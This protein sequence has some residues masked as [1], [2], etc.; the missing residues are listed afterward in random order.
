M[1]D[2]ILYLQSCYYFVKK[3]GKY[4]KYIVL[5]MVA[6]RKWT[7]LEFHYPIC[8]LHEFQICV[9]FDILYLASLIWFL[10]R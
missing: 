8:F 6:Y 7:I 3:K 10:F 2:A 1:T 9:S 5:F 4:K